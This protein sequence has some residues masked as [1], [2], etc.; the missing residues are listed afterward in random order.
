MK[1]NGGHKAQF[2]PLQ[3]FYFRHKALYVSASSVVAYL[4]K[5]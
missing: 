4:F 1:G 3:I 5:I 2:V